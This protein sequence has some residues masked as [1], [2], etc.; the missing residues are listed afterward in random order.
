MRVKEAVSEFVVPVASESESKIVTS[1]TYWRF[2]KELSV[3]LNVI[4]PVA[5]FIVANDPTSVDTTQT[6][7][8]STRGST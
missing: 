2:A 5:A 7:K 8:G 6:D 1:T 4:S 3:K